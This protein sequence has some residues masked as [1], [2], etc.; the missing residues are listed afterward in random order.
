MAG[1]VAD[2]NDWESVSNASQWA[3]GAVETTGTPYAIVTDVVRSGSQAGRI[4][5]ASNEGENYN[6][7]WRRCLFRESINNSNADVLRQE[8][9]ADHYWYTASYR[10]NSGTYIPSGTLFWEMHGPNSDWPAGTSLVAP[11]AIQWRN[12]EWQY[13]QHT[14]QL[15]NNVFGGNIYNHS[16]GLTSKNEGSWRDWMVEILFDDPG[17]IRVWTRLEGESDF[18]Q[19]LNLSTA[20]GICYQTTKS[21]DHRYYRLEGVYQ[22]LPSP[23]STQTRVWLDNNGRHLS[24]ADARTVFGLNPPDPPPVNPSTP[25][26]TYAYGTAAN[27]FS[28]GSTKTGNQRTGSNG[29]RSSQNIG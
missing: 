8:R 28:G 29:Y 9:Y 24:L 20:P 13:R 15:S 23:T 2:L 16:L 26:T 14:G 5:L 10:I 1:E 21:E 7:G 19:V 22:P 27:G 6:A 12:N 3:G 18:T 17:V 25:T 11:H 4:T